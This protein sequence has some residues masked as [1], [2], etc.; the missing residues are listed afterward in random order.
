MPLRPRYIVIH[1]A[2]TPGNKDIS[3]ADI[4][5]F[6]KTKGW[7]GIGY[8]FVV[9]KDGT[10]EKGRPINKIGAHAEGINSLSIGI[11]F[12]GNGDISDF[13]EAQYRSGLALC[14]ELM[15]K[16]QIPVNKVIGHRELNTLIGDGK[17]NP[18]YRVNKTCPGTRVNMHRFRTL[19]SGAGQNKQK[20]SIKSLFSDLYALIARQGGSKELLSAVN[21]IR[22]SEEI[23]KL[24]DDI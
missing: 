23:K 6:H 24:I 8:H 22:H 19:L 12:S 18:Q 13:T 1:T 17:L 2:A 16:Y 10:V 20:K 21:K 4:D 11:C 9:R 15:D 7:S 14:L 3:A 5:R